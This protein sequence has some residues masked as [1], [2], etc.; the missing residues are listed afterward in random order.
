MYFG[1]LSACMSAGGIPW[2]WSYRQLWVLG[3]EAGSSVRADVLFTATSSLQPCSYREQW[4]GPAAGFSFDSRIL[5]RT[6]Y[7]LLLCHLSWLEERS[8]AF[9]KLQT[10]ILGEGGYEGTSAVSIKSTQGQE[11]R[12]GSFGKRPRISLETLVWRGGQRSRR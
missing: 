7:G 12:K 10:W 11:R 6:S 2:T 9:I 3:A 8:P 5:H 1:V 4:A